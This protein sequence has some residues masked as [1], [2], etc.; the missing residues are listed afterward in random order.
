MNI[1]N[2][3]RNTL[4]PISG[5]AQGAMVLRDTP[6]RDM[7]YEDMISVLRPKVDGSIHLDKL[8]YN[9]PLDFFIYFSSMTGVIGNMGQSNYTA[10]NTF[11]CSLAAQRRKRGLAASVVNIGVIIGAGYVTREV[12][13]AD[14]KNLRKGG[15][16]WMSETDFHSI[17]A[18]AI[19]AG[20]STEISEP[21]ISTGLRHVA[22]NSDYLPIWSDNP[23]FARFI[24][25]ESGA[26]AQK[27]SE[28][29]GASVKDRLQRADSKEVV[30]GVIA[31]TFSEKLR[32]ML[33]LD[34]DTEIM[35]TRTD[36]LGLDSLI[37]VDVRSWVLKSYQVNIPVLK[38]LGGA[39]VADLVSQILENIP[40]E[41]IP[42]VGGSIS[43]DNAQVPKVDRKDGSAIASSPHNRV[44]EAPTPRTVDSTEANSQADAS[45][46]DEGRNTPV[47][48]I[49]EELDTKKTYT[50]PPLKRYGKLGFTQSLFWFVDALMEDKTTLNHTGMFRL[51]ESLR[52]NDLK[53]AVRQVA[54][55]HEALRTC[56]FIQ[57]DQQVAQGV[58]EESTLE[59]ETKQ[60]TCDSQI[61]QEWDELKNHVYDLT[62]GQLVRI[63]LLSRSAVEHYLLIGCHHINLDGISHQVLMADI[64]CFYKRQPPTSEVVQ[65]FD[66]AVKQRE[67]YENGTWA[68]EV[69]FWKS[70][71]SILPDPLPLHRSRV[72][73][74]PV[75]HQYAVHTSKLR[76]ETKL[77]NRIRDVAK[78]Y[79]A[80]AYHFYLAAFNI[81]LYRFLGIEDIC[82]GMADA[83]RSEAEM[84]ES[85]GPYVNLLPL[86]FMA[87]RNSSQRF[88][89]TLVE[90]K[91]KTYAA[92]A[93]SSVP[94]EVLL[95]EV[96]VSRSPTH[97]PLFQAFIDYRQGTRER[98][99]FA[100]CPME[101]LDFEPGKTA[102]DISLDII[103]NPGQD[104]LIALMVQKN[105]Y[106]ESDGE[107]IMHCYEDILREFSDDPSLKVSR[108]WDFRGEDLQRAL[109]LGRGMSIFTQV[110]Y[111]NLTLLGPSFTSE[112]GETLL[113][114]FDLVAKSNPRKVAL[115][116]AHG[117]SL[118]YNELTKR[119]DSISSELLSHVAPNSN[120]AVFQER[121][122]DWVC[123]ML[124]IMKIGAVYVPLDP[125]TPGAR[126]AMVVK[127]CMPTAILTDNKMQANVADINCSNSTAIINVSQL[128]M[129]KPPV[130]IQ[131][132]HDAPALIL[133]TSGSTG[134]PKGISIKHFS[135][136]NEVEASA[137]F[138]S[139]NQD[140]V[141]L[142]QSSFSFD[143]SALQVFL[144]LALGGTLSMTSRAMRGDPSSITKFIVDEGVTFTCATPSEYR[145]W[146]NQGNE[147]ALRRSSWKTALSGG[148]PVT[149]A[150]LNSFRYFRK[151]DLR[152]FNGYG[153]TETTCSST[154]VELSYTNSY[155]G[156][157]PAGFASLNESIYILD[158]EMR[159][160]PPGLPGEVVIGG[161]GVA[162]GY[163][164][165]DEL[166]KAAFVPDI[167]A[168]QE[169]IQRGWKTMYRTKDRGRLITDVT[170]S[171]EGRVGDDTEVKLRGLRID[172]KDIE[173]AILASSD[174][175]IVDAAASLRS[176]NGSSFIVAHVVFSAAGSVQDRFPESLLSSLP[177]PR[178]MRPSAIVPIEKMPLTVSGKLDRRAISTLPIPRI[179]TTS[180]AS[181]SHTEGRLKSLWESVL[182]K[183][184]RDY[185]I[186]DA[187]SNFFHVGGSSIL[188]VEV[189]AQIR[190]QFGL[191]LQLIQLFESSTL[192]SMALLI[193]NND[194]S[195]KAPIDWH[196]ETRLDPTLDIIAQS[197]T[198]TPPLV[199]PK[200]VVLTGAT[201]F[202]GGHILRNLVDNSE[203]EGVICIAMRRKNDTIQTLNKVSCYQG[204]LSLPRLGLTESEAE[205]IF[206]QADTV[207]HN[208][209]DT[210]H[211]QSYQCIKPVNVKPTH[212]LVRLCLPRRIP[213][214][215]I[216]TA[217][218][219][220]FTARETFPEISAKDTPPPV[221]GSMGYD[222]SKWSSEMYLEQ[223]N[224]R[225]GLPVWIHRPSA[226]VNPAIVNGGV[227]SRN[228]FIHT[229]FK[230]SR[231]L[232]AVP[233]AP[234]I[235]GTLD[236]ISVEHVAARVV[237]DVFANKSGP[238]V[239]RHQTG[240]LTLPVSGM[241][242]YFEE[243]TGEKFAVLS[244]KEW[245]DGA[246]EMGLD[247]VLAVM[248]RN[249]DDQLGVLHFPR[250]VKGAR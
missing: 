31:E 89:D 102:Y 52:V 212:E 195:S 159:L 149:E 26:E 165:N 70:Q 202:L 169:Y 11:M 128:V 175:N 114:Q 10:A 187:D 50:P 153:P 200:T 56:F 219:G 201:G 238:V 122:T 107:I 113:H 231:Q 250:F 96:R 178:Y 87:R 57:D 151:A 162:C 154:K 6:T 83:N 150:L 9:D 161:V 199:R 43:K 37:A 68:N 58:M 112:W 29:G 240:D 194:G 106:A 7:S 60:I 25:R 41:L 136:R 220:M 64:E 137:R 168:T 221:D 73:T 126:L 34:I 95:N 237:D 127:N 16:M 207:I 246:E 91:T 32:T 191:S 218:V 71:Y 233:A 55:R 158:E 167:Y 48:S 121:A 148:E 17:F 213:I 222:A 49:S 184:L 241:E 20:Q 163:L 179:A 19:G 232:R 53:D 174:G 239:Y 69:A 223:A 30:H 35:A 99:S 140:S 125:D 5:V 123:S 245:A 189:Q 171:I 45:S 72:S 247:P 208:G 139:L 78:K 227:S 181:L 115:K 1:Y 152:L 203:I 97:S 131:A 173:Q 117:F 74:R 242:K 142:Q 225:Y 116:N 86:R 186:I 130:S 46:Q 192:S 67:A 193:E 47:S 18:E 39:S 54:Q 224:T 177:L 143:M 228:D 172:L 235:R 157:I 145:T 42:N 217:A 27:G 2:N 51:T 105:L 196:A 80:T 111:R 236:M 210:S 234:C 82:I 135:F 120:V 84:Q 160:Q 23:K 197:D 166:T 40:H 248:F 230:F 134:V 198:L 211:M 206:Q 22:A 133:Y 90:A 182:P 164:N 215:F 104:A 65:Y 124:T 108:E 93:N 13:H 144:A 88:K 229:L 146:L 209:A 138:Y 59:L 85:I 244:F 185:Y 155:Q 176:T 119:V 61:E 62:C 243:D 204:D 33:Q 190:D 249:A 214:H 141:I 132:S 188:L 226:I 100:G 15:Y 76:V 79:K 118:T 147:G 38:I 66:Y 156:P 63:I 94:F 28:K 216:S 170:L 75:L 98:L 77:A 180:T 110:L 8:F 12:S 183:D 81:L 14:Q 205:T 103:D 4:P 129:E 109:Q 44:S 92:L 3:I 21:E 101:M 36:E 24:I